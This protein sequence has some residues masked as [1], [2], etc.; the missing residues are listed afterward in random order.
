MNTGHLLISIGVCSMLLSCNGAVDR[1]QNSL[2]QTSK[3]DLALA[4]QERDQ[5]L[6]LVQEITAGM[7][8]IKQIED[9]MTAADGA[10]VNANRQAQILSD[11]EAFRMTLKKRNEELNVIEANLTNSTINNKEL[12][13]TIRA[14]RTQIDVQLK[15]IDVLRKQLVSAN[16]HIGALN[17][18]VDSLNE[19][20]SSVT[21]E[22]TT[23]QEE[24]EM[25]ENIL[26]TCYYAVAPKQELKSHNIIES[27]FLRKT[28]LMKGD[29]DKDFFITGDKRE[30]RC[31]PLNSGKSKLLTNHPQNSYRIV[32]GNDC[33][34]LY[35]TDPDQ[36][37]SLSNFLV[38]QI[39]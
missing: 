37:W 9:I 35:I 30:L 22:L 8:Q 36:F 27:G 11:M 16:E 13:E 39:D 24:S 10:G 18:T 3:Q 32:N 33:D 26:N 28:K 38:V 5:L 19:T 2:M 15:Q 31:L 7:E 17:Q 20:V 12:K 6:S 25:L 29:F 21:V 34:T 1:E 23:A 4:L 14:F